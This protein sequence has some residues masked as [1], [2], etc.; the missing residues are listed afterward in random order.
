MNHYDKLAEVVRV[1]EH[2]HEQARQGLRDEFPALD[3]YRIRN[4]TGH[5]VLLDS[6]TAIVSAR[7]VLAT[8]DLQSE[9]NMDDAKFEPVNWWRVIAP[10][11][12]L[13]CETSSEKEA[14]AS[15]RDGDTLQQLYEKVVAEW[16]TA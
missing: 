11:G 15:M 9:K 4:T 2:A 10:N 3:P 5:Y 16:R 12:D 14:R 7:A 8:H 6:L 1:L 13:W